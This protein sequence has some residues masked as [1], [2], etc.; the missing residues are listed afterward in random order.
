MTLPQEFY[1]K[2]LSGLT[3]YRVNWLPNHSLRLGDIGKLEDGL[4]TLY[5]DLEQ[6][7]IKFAKED[8]TSSLD[9]DYTSSDSASINF[10]IDASTVVTP[11]ILPKGKINI[12]FSKKNG[13]VFQMTKAKVQII[14]DKAD[15]ENAVLQR[16]QDKSWAKEWVIITELVITDQATII[17]S[18]SD[19]NSIDLACDVPGAL[20]NIP[21]ADPSLNL[22]L[23]RETGSS[24]K[25]LAANQLTPFYKI[26]GVKVPFLQ[27]PEF[28]IREDI[29]IDKMEFKQ[30]PFDEREFGK[31]NL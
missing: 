29:T 17:I 7:G 14:A 5:T 4:F 9:L 24:T 10:E 25:I 26:M 21:L 18:T 6:Q 3:Q 31:Q 15:L 2:Y 12:E 28:R 19:N 11:N 16:Y 27:R 13:V 20:L 8:N 23:I 1:I 22:K 30:L